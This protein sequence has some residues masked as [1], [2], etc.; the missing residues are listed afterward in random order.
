MSGGSSPSGVC[1]SDV[2]IIQGKLERVKYP[3]ILGHEA[4]GR[5]YETCVEIP[6]QL[7]DKVIV[8]PTTGCLECMYCRSK[9]YE[10]C[11]VSRTIGFELNGSHA[12]YLFVPV[13]N[14]IPTTLDPIHAAPL[15]CAGI[16]SYSAIK[17]YVMNRIKPV[18][19]T[20]LYGVGGLGH[21]AIQLMRKLAPSIIIA[22]D[23]DQSKLKL[24][25]KF[26]AEIVFQ[27]ASSEE[28]R[29]LSAGGVSFALD[30][31]GSD[32]S[33]ALCFDSLKFGGKLIVIGSGG[34][35]L[36][37]RGPD[38]KRRE[39]VGLITG[40]IHELQELVKFVE[41]GEIQIVTQRFSFEGFREAI[42]LIKDGK[43]VG[44]AILVPD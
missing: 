33:L 5:V 14:L 15:A 16:T 36:A 20:L 43:V 24:A 32:D 37:Y 21:I 27:K 25:E 6:K 12:E 34:G 41:K 10:M 7:S 9:S 8:Y 11:N 28:I 17:N 42:S 23:K 31:V 4:V 18:E 19:Y 26:G 13:E 22:I 38:K 30:F 1:G 44:R 2:H 40:S 39:I 29:K 35:T 3:L